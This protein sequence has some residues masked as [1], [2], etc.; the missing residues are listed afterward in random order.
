[1]LVDG[2]QLMILGMAVVFSLLSFLVLAV[3]GMS[4]FVIS[5]EDRAA[6]LD[7]DRIDRSV[8]DKGEVLAAVTAAIQAH[9]KGTKL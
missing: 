1:M 2:V 7:A 4:R 9:R 8:S 5:I 3:I 6:I